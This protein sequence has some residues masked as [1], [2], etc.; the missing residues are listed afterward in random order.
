M[1][2]WANISA[3]TTTSLKASS[4][5]CS[6]ICGS[7]CSG[8]RS[9]SSAE[10]GPT[11]RSRRGSASI[12]AA[13]RL[14]RSYSWSRRTSSAR[15]SSSP[16]SSSLGRGSSMR[17]LISASVAAIT[18]YSPASSS[19]RPCM[20]SMYC[21]YWRVISASGIS[22]MFR[23]CR[24]M[25]YSSRSSGPSKASRNTSRAC[26][27]MY[28]SRGSCEIGSPFTIANG[29]SACCGGVWA[30]GGASAAGGGALETTIFSCG[31][32]FM[33]VPAPAPSVGAQMHGAPHF[34]ECLAR[35]LARLV[36]A[37]GDDA[38]HQLRV[39]LELLGAPAHAA[40]LL[41]DPVDQ[42]LLA[43]QATDAGA[44]AT[45][46]HPL[47]RGLVG[48]ELVQVPHRTLLRVARVGAPHA[49]RIGLHSAQLL[50]DLIGL[51][52]QP[53]G[54]AVGLGHLAPVETRDLRRRGEQRLRLGQDRHSGA[55]EEPQQPLA[56]G[57]CDAVV[58]LH[59]RLGALQRFPFAAL[60]ELAA[61]LPVGGG[62][63]SPEALHR[64]LRLR[65][66]VRFT[67]VE[68]VE[69]PRGFAAELHVRH[70]VLAHGHVGGAVHQ[71]VGALQQRVTEE[72]VGPEILLLQLLLLILVTGYALAPA[73][74]RDHRQQ[75][76]QLRVLG[77]VRLDEQRRDPGIE[78]GRQP[79]DEHL[80]H[81]LLQVRGL[82]V[83]GREHVPVGHEEEAL[84]LV[85]QLHPVA[86]R[87]V[88]VAEVQPPGGSHARQDAPRRRRRTHVRRRSGPA[89]AGADA[90]ARP[91]TIRLWLTSR[92]IAHAP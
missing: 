48:V 26:G 32:C 81:V 4:I 1:W 29:I 14:K 55:F 57:H 22:R 24:R 90:C 40:D 47:A 72:A 77:H 3:R 82:V 59:Q 86:Q 66:E 9:L 12:P 83:A 10:V 35:D 2:W 54:V 68:V 84:V 65:L 67:P 16:S 41:H 31:L 42:R 78:A 39:V 75:Q 53:D 62:I 6:A 60:L 91:T 5:S 45:L 74:R 44:A 15:G 58:A 85:L 17:D 61:Q 87:A 36:G 92:I 33:R 73:E 13:A 46:V 89:G 80:V 27:G 11:S 52:A 38:A 56:I 18:R 51:L 8:C 64:A 34:V 25:R 20:S 70:L 7:V 50:H 63:A 21:M 49:C 71:D 37:L 88:I 69:A 43:V 30:G 76:V 28:R 79:V 19:C 23:F